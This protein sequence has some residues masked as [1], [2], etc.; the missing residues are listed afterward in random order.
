MFPHLYAVGPLEG[1]RGEV[2]I[3]DG[4]P[5]IARVS[6]GRVVVEESF[7]HRACFLV[8]AQVRRWRDTEVSRE[9]ASLAGIE[10][11][12]VATAAEAGLDVEQPFPFGILGHARSV[13]V[14]VF[15]KRDDS[16]HDAVG[17]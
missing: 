10:S 2:S 14:H 5:S 11:H 3:F 9:Y 7:A 16:R 8:Y 12:V 6:A 15:D 13:T 4:V 1:V 17:A